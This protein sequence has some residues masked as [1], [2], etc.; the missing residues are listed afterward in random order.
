[1]PF[2]ES[3]LKAIPEE[4]KIEVAFKKKKE[5]KARDSRSKHK[6]LSVS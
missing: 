3:N 5:R 2:L 1:M 6:N 4:F